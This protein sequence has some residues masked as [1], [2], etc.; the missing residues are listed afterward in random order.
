MAQAHSVTATPRTTPALREQES[1]C[2]VSRP[3]MRRRGVEAPALVTETWEVK[4]N[5]NAIDTDRDCQCV[6]TFLMM[7]NHEACE[8]LCCSAVWP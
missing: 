7:L 8:I 5:E 6:C 4:A 3:L 2:V 1:G